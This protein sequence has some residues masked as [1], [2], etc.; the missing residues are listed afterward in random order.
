MFGTQGYA[1]FNATPPKIVGDGTPEEA[2]PFDG[3]P[4]GTPPVILSEAAG[5]VEGS[6][7]ARET[8]HTPLLYSSRRQRTSDAVFLRYFE[9]LLSK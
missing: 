8:L 3:A 9:S 2:R 5:R 1:W 4:A 7:E 6:P